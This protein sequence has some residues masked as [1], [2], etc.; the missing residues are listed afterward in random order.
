MSAGGVSIKR[1]QAM[2]HAAESLRAIRSHRGHGH[3]MARHLAGGALVAES[4]EDGSILTIDAAGHGSYTAPYHARADQAHAVLG[5][6][7]RVDTGLAAQPA[8]DGGGV[9]AGEFHSRGAQFGVG[10]SLQTAGPGRG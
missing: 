10:Q 1:L 9:G 7:R 2:A 4:D 6:E 8:G 5:P 3:G